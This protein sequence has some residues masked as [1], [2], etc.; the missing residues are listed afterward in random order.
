MLHAVKRRR[1]QD[2]ICFLPEAGKAV[3]LAKFIQIITDFDGFEKIMTKFLVAM[4]KHRQIAAIARDKF[5]V[6]IHVE[7]LD[8]EPELICQRKERHP[9]LVTEMAAV[10]RYQR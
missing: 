7:N 5:R 6:G 3:I 8:V 1:R 9:H 4:Q 10:S 2:A